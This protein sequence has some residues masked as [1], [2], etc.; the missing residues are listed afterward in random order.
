MEK[1]F[2]FSDVHGFYD[3]LMAAL[4]DAG[5]DASDPHHWLVSLGD[6]FDRGSKPREVMDF[7]TQ[8]PRAIV[9]CGNHEDLL[10]QC[11]QQGHP[12]SR[13]YLNGTV[14][15][16]LRLGGAEEFD[17]CVR[18]AYHAVKHFIFG[19]RDYFETAHYVFTHGWLPTDERG[20]LANWRAAE[21][22]Q[23]RR[24]RWLNGID[25]AAL[26]HTIEKTVVCGHWSASYGHNMT[27]GTQNDHSPFYFQDSLIAL[28]ACTVVSGKVNVVVLEDEFL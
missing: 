7:L 10:L 27:E 15:T 1:L 17:L 3:E 2:C 13:D 9:V 28:D 12:E 24:A 14:D 26:G 8:S 5:F 6:H 11:L 25:Q 4:A 20:V 19:M 18:S 16:V 21:Y 22:Q 23:W